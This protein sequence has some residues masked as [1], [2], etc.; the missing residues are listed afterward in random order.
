[1]TSATGLGSWPGTDPAAAADQVMEAF[2]QSPFLPELPARGQGADMVGRALGLIEGLGF[3][4][5]ATGWATTANRG[6]AQRRAAA[7]ARDD[8]DIAAERLQD[9]RGDF[10]L[11]LAGP[12][13]LAALV[14]RGSGQVLLSDPGAG[15]D[16]AQAWAE[17]AGAWCARARALLPQ[18]T[19]S[20]QVD[21]PMLVAIVAGEVGTVSGLGRHRP[22]PQDQLAAAY[23]GLAAAAGPLAATVLHCCAPGLGLEWLPAAGFTGAS[24]DVTRL[25][26]PA[27]DRLA[28]YHHDGGRL[29]L[30]VAA[31]D[32]PADQSAAPGLDALLPPVRRLLEDLSADPASGRLTVTPA[33]GLAGFTVAAAIG[34]GKVLTRLGAA[35]DETAG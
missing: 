19:L 3:E 14:A 32:R 1:M 10:H 2:P 5:T 33:C 29:W 35:L 28:A 22:V 8:L 23:D 11:S 9:H 20:L 17:A 7:L 4:P 24:L 26:H 16:L 27:R 6:R 15:R 18:V 12:W 30:G 34:L 13:T 31:T 25:D 21:E